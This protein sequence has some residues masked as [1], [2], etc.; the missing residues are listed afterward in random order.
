MTDY[1]AT[2]VSPFVQGVIQIGAGAPGPVSFQGRGVSAIARTL[3]GA[4]QGDYVLTLDPGLDGGGT[5]VLETAPLATVPVA[6]SVPGNPRTMLTVRGT[7]AAS[8]ITTITQLAA[9]YGNIV[10]GAF[11]PAAPGAQV[12]VLRVVLSIAGAGTDPFGAAGNGC[13]V[14]AYHS[15]S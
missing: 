7:T 1:S 6:P 5:A 3:G 12:T 13:E 15:E 4:A 10:A 8:G 14:I 2:S 9:S 11:V